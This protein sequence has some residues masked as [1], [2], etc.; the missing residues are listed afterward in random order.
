MSSRSKSRLCSSYYKPPVAIYAHVSANLFSAEFR[1]RRFNNIDTSDN[2]EKLTNMTFDSADHI[3]L[4]EHLAGTQL[5]Y[6]LAEQ[7]LLVC[8]ERFT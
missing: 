2:S 3:D 4:T 8:E 6:R 5:S 1:F 7:I